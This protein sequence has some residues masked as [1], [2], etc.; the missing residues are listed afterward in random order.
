MVRASKGFRRGTRSRLKRAR[1]DKFKPQKFLKE[2]REGENVVIKQEP[3]SHLGMPHPRFKG[4]TGIVTGKRGRAYMINLKMGNM[5][6][7]IISRPEHL[8]KLQDSKA[9][10]PNNK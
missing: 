6:K 1:R 10:K 4:K 5:V 9:Q 2:F 7:Q 3:S 8:K